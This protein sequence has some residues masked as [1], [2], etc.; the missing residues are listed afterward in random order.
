[1]DTCT[2]AH[3]CASAHTH[4][5]QHFVETSGCDFL[6]LTSDLKK[7]IPNKFFDPY[8]E[9]LNDEEVNFKPIKAI[10]SNLRNKTVLSF[11]QTHVPSFQTD[12]SNR[13][14]NG[15]VP[16]RQQLALF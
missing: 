15:S 7:F 11:H 12:E 6:L 9:A 2:H 5:H 1:M 8:F 14:N 16:F 10:K 4:T 13:K 3:T